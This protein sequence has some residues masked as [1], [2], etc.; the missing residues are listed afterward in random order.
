MISTARQWLLR[1]ALIALSV[2]CA[3]SVAERVNPGEIAKKRYLMGME[4]LAASDYE[5]AIGFFKQVMRV[6]GFVRLAAN[7]KLRIGDAL[8]LQE[9]YEQAISTYRAFLREY[10]GDENSPYAQLR[11][12]H[13]YYEQIPSDWFL[14]PPRY[15]RQQNAVRQA[16]AALRQFVRLYPTSALREQAQTMLDD[17]E[18]QLY[19]HEVYVARFY[20]D[21]G[22]HNGVVQR[23]E[24]AFEKYPEQAGTPDNYLML[25]QAYVKTDKS[26]SAQA[27]Y[28]AYLDRFP[29]GEFRADASQNLATLRALQL[30]P[31]NPPETPKPDTPL[32]PDPPFAPDP[33][34]TP[35]TEPPTE[36]EPAAD[37]AP[38]P[39]PGQ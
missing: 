12:G 17:C 2:S 31:R 34:P 20:H 26:E 4:A 7:A 39:E 23:L 9:R 14:A 3:A 27:M 30:T 22:K 36:R 16:A 25:A 8:F 11:I 35:E 15:E 21:R 28:Q 1:S 38:S 33:N 24:R 19:E 37:P 6:P 5:V 32:A 10:E 13:A 29:D 18:Q